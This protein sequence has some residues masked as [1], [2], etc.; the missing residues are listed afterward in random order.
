MSG[1]NHYVYV[2]LDPRKKGNFTYYENGIGITFDHEPFY[3]GEGKNDRFKAHLWESKNLNNHQYKHNKIRSIWLNKSEPIIYKICENMNQKDALMLER[4][5]GFLVGRSNLNLG[6]LTNLV[7]LGNSG[8]NP[9][10]EDKARQIEKYKETL[11]KDPSIEKRR[12][13][14]KKET[15]NNNPEI[16]INALIKNKEYWENLS[17]KER[18]VIGNNISLGHLNRTE[19]DK[20]KSYEKLLGTLEKKT[21]IEKQITKDKQSNIHKNRS[22]EKKKEVRIKKQIAKI[23]SQS[24]MGVNN[25]A[26]THLDYK[27]LIDIYFSKISNNHMIIIY[28]KLMNTNLTNQAFKKFYGILNFPM[29]TLHTQRPKLKK[30]YLKFVEENKNKINWFVENYERL[31]YEYFLN[32]QRDRHQDI[33]EYL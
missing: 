8:T 24:V 26:Y 29:N 9:S 2:Y 11:K 21:D 28:N 16:K 13:E 15:Y 7:D 5:L 10:K 19:E 3:I 31:E 1:N 33:I 6:P 27:L 18:K 17:D 14:H 20:Q 22:L 23:E 4:A 25:P 32:R 12:Q 30:E